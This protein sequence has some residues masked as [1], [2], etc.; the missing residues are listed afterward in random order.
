[1]RDGKEKSMEDNK[2]DDDPISKTENLLNL[3]KSVA[4]F[5]DQMKKVADKGVDN[6]TSKIKSIH[7][8]LYTTLLTIEIIRYELIFHS[9]ALHEIHNQ[10]KTFVDKMYE[11]HFPKGLLEKAEDPK[12][13]LYDELDENPSEKYIKFRQLKDDNYVI[14]YINTLFEFNIID[15]INPKKFKQDKS[16]FIE[17]MIHFSYEDLGYISE[18]ASFLLEQCEMIK[19]ELKNE[20]SYFENKN[21]Y[22]F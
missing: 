7:T 20:K 9:G 5:A 21:K 11:K 17:K 1:M 12:S 13:N 22:T 8:N 16:L 19:N 15:H 6:K 10:L 14:S 4:I 2:K 18:K 3:Q